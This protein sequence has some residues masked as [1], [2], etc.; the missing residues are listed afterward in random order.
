MIFTLGSSTAKYVDC[1][2]RYESLDFISGNIEWPAN[3]VSGKQNSLFPSGPVIKCL[4]LTEHFFFLRKR[5]K[6]VK[7]TSH[8]IYSDVASA[9]KKEGFLS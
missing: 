9:G 8:N 5:E 2:E 6:V 4:L 7:T 3:R 1:T